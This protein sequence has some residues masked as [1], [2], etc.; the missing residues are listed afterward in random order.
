V[1]KVTRGFKEN[2]HR[3]PPPCFLDGIG[4]VERA[5]A[6]PKMGKHWVEN[7]AFIRKRGKAVFQ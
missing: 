4:S 5:S 1:Q 7:C 2:R 6:V 3:V